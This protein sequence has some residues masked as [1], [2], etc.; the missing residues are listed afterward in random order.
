[1][2]KNR[3]P[4]TIEKFWCS[5]SNTSIAAEIASCVFSRAFFI[6]CSVVAPLLVCVCCFLPY[7]RSTFRGYW[8]SRPRWL[9]LFEEARAD[10]TKCP[11]RAVVSFFA[12]GSG[13]AGVCIDKKKV[14][15]LYHSLYK[16]LMFIGAILHMYQRV[17][18][19]VDVSES[20]I[21]SWPPLIT[22]IKRI[23]SL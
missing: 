10:M 6:I 5:A 16:V 15:E 4:R 14:T 20:I 2:L 8:H 18:L 9:E 7:S 1:M 22:F 21:A 13:E 17:L 19:L 11:L 23:Y 12:L 3:V